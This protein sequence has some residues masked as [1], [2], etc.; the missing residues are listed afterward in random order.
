MSG[1]NNLDTKENGT[2]N[3][4]TKYIYIYILAI[5]LIPEKITYVFQS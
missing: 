3:L 2:N 1:T 4:D 5:S